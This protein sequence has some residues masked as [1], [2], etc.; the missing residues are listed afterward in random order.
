MMELVSVPR[1]IISPQT[2]API[3]AFVQNALVAV[4]LLTG[5]TGKV[6][7]VRKEVFMDIVYNLHC[8]SKIGSRLID[9]NQEL[10]EIENLR[11]GLDEQSAKEVDSI[12]ESKR[13]TMEA[14]VTRD[15][16]IFQDRLNNFLKRAAKY[17][18][19][20]IDSNRA[21]SNLHAL[22]SDVPGSLLLS[23][24]FPESFSYHLSGVEIEDGIIL[25]GSA[26]LSKK[27]MGTKQKHGLVSRVYVHLLLSRVFRP[28]KV[29]SD[30]ISET[31]ALVDQWYPLHCISIGLN[32][33][34]VSEK[35]DRF[36]RAKIVRGME[37]E[38][39]LYKELAEKLSKTTVG[40]VKEQYS[41]EY[42]QKANNILNS[43]RNVGD[44]LV[45]EG[46]TNGKNND[47]VIAL[48]SGAK[49]DHLNCAQ[50]A[51]CL[52][53]QNVS[54]KR[55]QSTM[56]GGT[57]TLTCFLP[58]EMT[59]RA[60][61]FISSCFKGGLYPDEVFFH[62][63]GGR[64][65]VVD[66]SV[67]TKDSGYMQ[68]R[69]AR[70]MDNLRTN[71]MGMVVNEL[72]C[73]VSFLYGGDMLSARVPIFNSDGH[74]DF[75]CKD[76][77]SWRKSNNPGDIEGFMYTV[78]RAISLPFSNEVVNNYLNR[79]VDRIVSMAEGEIPKNSKEFEK[80]LSH[81]FH[82]SRVPDGTPVGLIAT[83]SITERATQMT[84]SFFHSAGIGERSS[85]P[86]LVRLNEL[87]LL[88]EKDKLRNP[89]CTFLLAHPPQG[90][91][92][93]EQL[94]YLETAITPLIVECKLSNMVRRVFIQYSPGTIEKEE[95]DSGSECLLQ[96]DLLLALYEEYPEYGYEWEPLCCS[97]MRVY[98][99]GT[100]ESTPTP[101]IR[102]YRPYVIRLKLSKFNMCNSR[103]SPLMIAVKIMKK[104]N[105]HAV[106]DTDSTLIIKIPHSVEIGCKSA[107]ECTD[108]IHTIL[109]KLLDIHISGIPDIKD[110]YYNEKDD[111][112]SKQWIIET[113]GSN[114]P[115]LLSCPHIQQDTFLTN[116]IMST[117]HYLG[118]DAAR[119]VLYSQLDAILD[120]S[121][122][123]RH[124]ALLA[125]S[126]TF[127]GR[128]L[129][130]SRTFMSTSS[131]P[132]S[133]CCFEDVSRSF[134]ETATKGKT[135]RCKS[136]VSNLLLGRRPRIGTGTH[137]LIIQ[138]EKVEVC[139][140]TQ[141]L[142]NEVM[143]II[144]AE[145]GSILNLS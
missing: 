11:R 83:S 103:L 132:L 117:Y 35:A 6:P 54:G 128:P 138:M 55:V 21:S 5:G 32:D 78:R 73:V 141:K 91:T 85:T 41:Y 16:S 145:I 22:K 2:G 101:G 29:L 95:E 67:K 98:M 127:R 111:N 65:G 58:G 122:D 43:V 72:G 60:R 4:F 75:F 100:A 17:Y 106:C 142:T 39:F 61:G 107:H 33:G 118:I 135:D 121:A 74:L 25:P 113:N 28:C 133:K 68:K 44:R 80:T 46:M 84:L 59:P 86:L 3:I 81:L 77:F 129:K 116:D 96:R 26:P 110:V 7:S 12:Y 108:I 126:M 64:E 70:A 82:V 112:G 104:T 38:A 14:V 23:Y 143:N 56:A 47:L 30:W 10:D 120:G 137:D 49:G 57:K 134:S 99:K 48:S 87:I 69:I 102:D 144:E 130:T 119:E 92:K 18:P 42:E 66:T 15:N 94:K 31:Y 37:K 34:S 79:S 51:A 45:K 19:E 140:D 124:Y 53:Q 40:K 13:Q 105:F 20:C 63:Q 27:T 139:R 88:S 97:L 50:I 24:T 62:A 9:L 1:N 123:H 8:R 136:L 115:Q 114:I 89:S 125:D 93:K 52:G 76:L 131:G 109:P 36:I 71:S 90:S